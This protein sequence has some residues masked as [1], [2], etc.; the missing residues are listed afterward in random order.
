MRKRGMK[1]RPGRPKG[2]GK[3]TRCGGRKMD[4]DFAWCG[5]CRGTH[6]QNAEARKPKTASDRARRTCLACGKSFW[7]EGNWNRRCPRCTTALSGVVPVP[8]CRVFI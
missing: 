2:K 8:A 3:C 1:R 4:D 6:R 5:S 7:S